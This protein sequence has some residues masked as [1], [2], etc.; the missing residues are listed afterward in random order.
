VTVGILYAIF[1]LSPYKGD[2][3]LGATFYIGGLENLGFVA[4]TYY[5]ISAISKKK[6]FNLFFSS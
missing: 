5:Q 1:L 6:N 2:V 3:T 4:V